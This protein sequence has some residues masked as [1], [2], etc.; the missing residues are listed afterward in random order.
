MMFFGA[1]LRG[2]CVWFARRPSAFT[3]LIMFGVMAPT[4]KVVRDHASLVTYIYFQTLVLAWLLNAV[5]GHEPVRA[6]TEHTTEGRLVPEI[7]TR[8]AY[9]R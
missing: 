1:I 7:R 5:F 4:I 6:V 8:P 3:A 9:S 2:V